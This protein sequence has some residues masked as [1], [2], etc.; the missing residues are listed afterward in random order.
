[1]NT[2]EIGDFVRVAIGDLVGKC[3]IVQWALGGFIWFQDDGELIKANDDSGMVLP[4]IHIAASSV[5]CTCLPATITLTKDCGYDLRP[6]DAVCVACGPEFYRGS[7]V[8]HQLC[9]HLADIKD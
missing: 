4:F 8:C 2:I 7:C 5:E 9:W 6:G 1:V 3:G